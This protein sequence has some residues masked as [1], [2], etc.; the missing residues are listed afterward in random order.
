[1]EH[2]SMFILS[3]AMNRTSVIDHMGKAF[4]RL[5][6]RRQCLFRHTYWI[7]SVQLSAVFGFI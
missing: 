2:H 1:M 5:D 6:V 4:L 7:T 3:A